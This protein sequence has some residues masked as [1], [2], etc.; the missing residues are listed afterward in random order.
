MAGSS[1]QKTRRRQEGHRGP[2][3][4]PLLIFQGV[5]FLAIPARFPHGES[6]QEGGPPAD[7]VL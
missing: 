6:E 4:P 2:E 1:S 5:E 3:A 7:C